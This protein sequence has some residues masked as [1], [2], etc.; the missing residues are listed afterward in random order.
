M[1]NNNFTKY[2]IHLSTPKILLPIIGNK[3]KISSEYW[4]LDLGNL[5][6]KT[7]LNI[8]DARINRIDKHYDK[9]DI[10]LTQIKL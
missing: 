9:Y 10:S 6:I 5:N 7:N 8:L 3:D 2:D 4:A 1:Y